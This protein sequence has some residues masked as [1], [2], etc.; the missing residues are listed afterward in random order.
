[1]AILAAWLGAAVTAEGK[2]VWPA[3]PSPGLRPWLETENVLEVILYMTE[4]LSR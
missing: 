2:L 3:L 4:N 1:M